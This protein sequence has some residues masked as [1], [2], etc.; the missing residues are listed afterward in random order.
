M[1]GLARWLP[2][3]LAA[4]L[5]AAAPAEAQRWGVREDAPIL[6]RFDRDGD[7]HLNAKERA[8]AMA[9][10]ARGEWE[11]NAEGGWGGASAARRT[12][13][14]QVRKIKPAD[15][16]KYGN[17]PLYDAAVLRTLFLQFDDANWEEELDAFKGTDVLLPATVTVDGR[18]YKDVGV[19]FHG[20]TSYSSTSD[21]QKRSITLEFDDIHKD[22]KLLGYRTLTLLNSAADPTFLRSVLFMQVARAYYPALKANFVR[23]AINGERW[24]VYVNQQHFNSD[25]TQEAV[26]FKGARWKVPGSPRS[27]GGL[28]YFGDDVDYYRAV[29]D[30]KSKDKPESW[31]ALMQ[32]CRVLNQTPVEKLPTELPKVLD[33][34]NVLRFMATEN[35]LIN[36]D[37]YW[38]RA[39][40]Y[41]IY[42]DGKGIF[43]IVPHDANETWRPLE[44]SGFARRSNGSF[45]QPGTVFLDPLVAEGD[46]NK[47]L[48]SRLLLVPAWKQKYLGYVRD[49]NDKWL[50][51]K[52]LGPIVQ[53]YH[54]LIAADVYQDDHK[55][56]SNEDFEAAISGDVSATARNSWGPTAPPE[57]SL[58]AFVIQRNAWLTRYLAKQ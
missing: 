16:K 42:Q 49:V 8:E 11:G 35:A 50:N 14:A 7:G 27:R 24:G 22:Q 20:N 45:S 30:I 33:V 13:P 52:T 40:D 32:L 2:G 21:G 47:P 9:A 3:L 54:D 41:S 58:K 34:D 38:T 56:F 17:E 53:R 43:H 48:I 23:V 5:L 57:I 12:D 4:A 10:H 15:V 51:W 19:H 29:F 39:S 36:T 6:D 44:S 31:E 1:R 46:G 28:E 37:G 26:D 25:F 55:L 18:V